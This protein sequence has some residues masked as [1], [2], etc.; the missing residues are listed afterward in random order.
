MGNPKQHYSDDAWDIENSKWRTDTADFSRLVEYVRLLIDGELQSRGT[1]LC[2]LVTDEEFRAEVQRAADSY[3][4]RHR[5]IGVAS[6]ATLWLRAYVA[7]KLKG[8][9]GQEG[10]V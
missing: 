7:F 4:E 3:E 9:T 1:S 2:K 6:H 8:L 10:G 5:A